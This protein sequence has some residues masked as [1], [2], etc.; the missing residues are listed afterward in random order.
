MQERMRRL[1]KGEFH[2][3]W[4]CSSYLDTL[5]DLD[6]YAHQNDLGKEKLAREEISF[7]F[8]WLWDAHTIMLKFLEWGQR[9]K[10]VWCTISL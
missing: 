4:S 2:E 9:W 1:E 3:I 10:F 8:F 5:V 7:F 6:E